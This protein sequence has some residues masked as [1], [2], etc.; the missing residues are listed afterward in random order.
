MPPE[1]LDVLYDNN[2]CLMVASMPRRIGLRE[3]QRAVG[4][5]AGAPG[6]PGMRLP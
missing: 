5:V 6:R 4:G 1:S 3:R 2:H